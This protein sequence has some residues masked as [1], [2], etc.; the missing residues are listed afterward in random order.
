MWC[1]RCARRCGFRGKALFDEVGAC[2]RICVM[3]AMGVWMDFST[4]E[5]GKYG[6]CSAGKSGLI[7]WTVGIFVGFLFGW[8]VGSHCRFGECLPMIR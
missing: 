1:A 6:E 2:V 8:V 7:C 4:F 3:A 5:P